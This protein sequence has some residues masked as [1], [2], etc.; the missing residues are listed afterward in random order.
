MTLEQ[1]TEQLALKAARHTAEIF[2]EEQNLD[3]QE[4]LERLAA[5]MATRA[6]KA[7]VCAALLKDWQIHRIG[8]PTDF[9]RS[10]VDTMNELH[11]DAFMAA[12][13]S[14]ELVVVAVKTLAAQKAGRA[15]A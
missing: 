2:G 9:L 5:D 6:R 12:E 4:L 15:I 1:L 13:V 11:T 10:F 3:K 14:R 8:D 7:Q